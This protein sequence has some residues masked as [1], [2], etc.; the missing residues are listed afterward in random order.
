MK[1]E[2]LAAKFPNMTKKFRK[3]LNVRTFLEGSIFRDRDGWMSTVQ[4]VKSKFPGNCLKREFQS[5]L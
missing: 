5:H 4:K 2:V 3:P 1:E